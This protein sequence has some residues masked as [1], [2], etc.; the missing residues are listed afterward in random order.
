MSKNVA[1]DREIHGSC[2]INR[3]YK[4]EGN[5]S[6]G[7][8]VLS[9]EGTQG[10]LFK[11]QAKKKAP[12]R[13]HPERKHAAARNVRPHEDRQDGPQFEPMPRKRTQHDRI[14]LKIA[15]VDQGKRGLK[16]GV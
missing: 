7:Q 6:L 13:S 9:Q 2:P 5:I 14:K 8:S 11:S 4:R 12:K 15:Q 3:F 1:F 16:T 10:H